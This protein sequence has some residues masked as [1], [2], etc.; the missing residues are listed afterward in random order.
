MG[1]LPMSGSARLVP[2]V[3]VLMTAYNREAYIGEAIESVLGQTYTDFE[4]IIVDDG[5][6]D[7]TVEV[8]RKY[9][10]DPRV[11]V[12]ENEKNLGDYP[13]RNH[14]STFARGEYLKFH[15]SDDVMYDDCLRVMVSALDS[16]PSAAMA[17][18][19]SRAWPGARCPMVLT[20]QLA[21]EREFLGIGLF[22]LGPA[23]ALIRR[24]AFEDLGRFPLIGLHSDSVF[25][26][27]VCRRFDVV[28]VRGDLFWYRVHDGQELGVTSGRERL[29][30]SLQFESRRWAALFEDDCPLPEPV[31]DIA[32][33]N[34]AY[35]QFK[36]VIRE[37]RAGAL[38]NAARRV[39]SG[40]ISIAQWLRYLR[41]PRRRWDAGTPQ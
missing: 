18:T 35:L 22:Q 10:S 24:R 39:T 5:S 41:R 26:L 19:S 30:A 14:A 28:L 33:R 25:W 3:S 36:D 1:S 6:K 29:D 2:R 7:R 4:L 8:A 40:G 13:N 21:F 37:V 20:P 32:R 31:R 38:S 17:L 15:D 11:R 16:T 9:L 27:T 34:V 12:V 23:C